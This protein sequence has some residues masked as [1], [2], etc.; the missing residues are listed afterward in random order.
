LRWWVHCIKMYHVGGAFPPDLDW[1]HHDA[2]L[3]FQSR[4]APVP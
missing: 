4:L 3:C 2:N 1:V